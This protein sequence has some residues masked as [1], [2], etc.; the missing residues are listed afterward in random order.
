M[1]EQGESCGYL[2]L[3]DF[4][5]NSDLVYL[6]YNLSEKAHKGQF[7]DSGDPYFSHPREVAE[8]VLDMIKPTAITPAIVNLVCA[9]LLHDTV[10]DC[11]KLSIEVIQELI[12]HEVGIIVDGVS[13]LRSAKPKDERDR[14]NL[15]HFAQKGHFHPEVFVIKLADRLH[16]MRT[17][18]GIKD[19]ERRQKIADET[20]RVYTKLAES[21][22]MWEVKKELEDLAFPYAYP[23]IYEKI[24]TAVENDPRTQSAF[25][26][27]TV[28]LLKQSLAGCDTEFSIETRFNSYWAIYKKM[29]SLPGET[30]SE[31][32]KDISDVVS[33]RVIIPGSEQQSLFSLNE[34]VNESL[35]FKARVDSDAFNDF[36]TQPSENGYSALHTTIIVPEYGAVEI[37]FATQEMED[38]NKDGIITWIREGRALEEYRRNIVFDE[39]GEAWFVETHATWGDVVKL[40]G[41]PQA[42][43]VK[44]NRNLLKLTQ[45]AENAEIF[46]EI[47]ELIPKA[48]S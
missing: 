16:N 47:Y 35:E 7:R 3:Q 43:G 39:G 31:S 19:P 45:L 15:Q 6:A 42:T 26:S 24:R 13:K 40:T 48:Q 5:E 36:V 21:M 32:I 33:Y 44:V 37:A 17:I 11:G 25:I 1:P 28:D 10:E 18:D 14:E 27:E 12:G 29:R 23:E 34:R 38:F 46:E 2:N 8:N 30:F 41:H 20:L 4:L 9:S 22:G